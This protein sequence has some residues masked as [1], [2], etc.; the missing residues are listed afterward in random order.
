MD[1]RGTASTARRPV[2]VRQ[3]AD[4]TQTRLSQIQDVARGLSG[5]V[6]T[7]VEALETE[8]ASLIRPHKEMEPTMTTTPAYTRANVLQAV[9]NEAQVRQDGHLPS[10]LPG[11]TTTFVDTADLVG[12]LLLRWHTRL[13]TALERAMGEYPLD[14]EAAVVRAW[15]RAR[16]ESAGV[17]LVLDRL[18]ANPP[19]EA[20]A[21]ALRTT[22]HNDWAYMAVAAGLASTLDAAATPVGRSLETKARCG[23]HP[24]PATEF[25]AQPS[26]LARL[27]DVLT[28]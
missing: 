1:T 19:N 20:V 14:L 15:R 9:I 16:D 23:D 5:R 11:V 2:R 28:A 22:A 8:T 25:V 17:R 18:A 3:C 21:R 7:A 24:E 27:R 6:T 10:D 4:A 26:L 12:A 13:A